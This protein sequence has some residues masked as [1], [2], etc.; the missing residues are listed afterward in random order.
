MKDSNLYLRS[1]IYMQI[2]IDHLRGD[3]HGKLNNH[4]SSTHHLKQVTLHMYNKIKL[5]GS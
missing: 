3:F 4:F 2:E 5:K 1:S